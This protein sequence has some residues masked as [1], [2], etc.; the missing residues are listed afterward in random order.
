[1]KNN[2]WVGLMIGV[3]G[4]LG[5]AAKSLA[6]DGTEGNQDLRGQLTGMIMYVSNIERSIDF[7]TDVVGLKTVGR[8]EKDGKLVEILMSSSG[9]FLDGMMLTLQQSKKDD[10]NSGGMSAQHGPL[11]FMVPSNAF[12]KGKLESSGYSVREEDANHLYSNDPDGHPIMFYQLD[13][14]IIS[15]LKKQ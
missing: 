7:Y 3:V 10:Q 13:P 9:Q 11:I 8:V 1:M 12:Y 14:R 4:L 15:S 6:A 5:V 2:K